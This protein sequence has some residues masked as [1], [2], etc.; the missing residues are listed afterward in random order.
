VNRRGRAVLAV[1]VATA[2]GAACVDGPPTTTGSER[3]MTNEVS[4][5]ID[6]PLSDGLRA[7][8]EMGATGTLRAL[9]DFDWDAVH[10]FG[11]G[12]TAEQVEAAAG[13]PVL[14]DRRYYDAGNLFVFTLDGA[15]VRAVSVVPD[16]LR[17]D[18]PSWGA[19]VRLEPIGDDT[20]AILK[21]S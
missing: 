19:A 3:S 10:V 21:L 2:L 6:R 17:V 11:E 5:T 18:H 14:R 15:V 20:P 13:A 7:L 4:I 12:A 9:T 8:S 1:V 16:L